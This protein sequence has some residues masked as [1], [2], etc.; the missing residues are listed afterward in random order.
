M[1]R[2]GEDKS[3]EKTIRGFITRK[4]LADSGGAPS[5]GSN[6]RDSSAACATTTN[7]DSRT[8][9]GTGS[10]GQCAGDAW[11]NQEAEC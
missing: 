9:L 7:S 3:R 11:Q 10:G 6:C 1:R 8:C 4:A 2:T 5:T